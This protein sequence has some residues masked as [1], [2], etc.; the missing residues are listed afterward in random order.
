MARSKGKVCYYCGQAATGQEHVPPKQIFKAFDCDC[1]TVPSCED[2]NT[3]KSFDDQTIIDLLMHAVDWHRRRAPLSQHAA[4]ALSLR[5]SSFSHTK[6]RI[7]HA[8]LVDHPMLPEI[9]YLEPGTRIYGWMQ[10]VAAALVFDGAGFHDA[11]IDWSMAVVFSP[12]FLSVPKAPAIPL[13]DAAQWL[14]DRQQ[15][16][17]AAD[18]SFEWLEGWSAQPKPY[19]RDIFAFHVAFDDQGF[20]G[21]RLQFYGESRWYVVAGM[22]DRTQQSLRERLAKV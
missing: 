14:R 17:D 16:A 3:S 15:I 13:E 22:S 10:H 5:F 6:R 8:N 2:H 4:E 11:S 7:D 12:T 9:P 19:P 18:R 20:V 1:I 21:L